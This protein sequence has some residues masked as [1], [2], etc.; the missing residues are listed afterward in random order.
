VEKL[1]KEYGCNVTGI[2][3]GDLVEADTK[4]RSRQLISRNKA[5]L[6][7]VCRSNL[8]P[9]LDRIDRAIFVRGTPA[10]VGKSAE[11]EEEAASDV[12]IAIKDPERNTYTWW[13][14]KAEIGGVLFDIRHHGKAGRLPW[15]APNPLAQLATETIFSYVGQRIPDLVIRSHNH[16]SLD[17]YDNYPC[18]VIALPSWQLTTEFGY[19]NGIRLADIGGVIILCENGKAT[20]IKKRYAPRQSKTLVISH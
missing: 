15:T 8:E 20:V 11:Y 1:K 14:V 18:R 4:G 17:T 10:H 12:T 19:R 3:N 7:K 16:T 13:E 9:A 5:V 6:L 2:F